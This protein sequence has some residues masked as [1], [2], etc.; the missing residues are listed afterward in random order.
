L[1]SNDIKDYSAI[2]D[3]VNQAARLQAK[4]RATEILVS[5]S[6]YEHVA[7]AYPN[8]Q[9]E[10]LALKGF[11]EPAAA[12]RLNGKPL[13]EFA[14]S[15]WLEGRPA[16]NWCAVTFAIFGSGCLGKDI[17]AAIVLVFGAGSATTLAAL[18]RRLDRS[19]ARLPLLAVTAF[20]ASAVLISLERQRRQRRECL[21][22]SSCL[23]MTPKE[24]RGAYIAAASAAISLG[25]VAFELWQH[26]VLGHPLIKS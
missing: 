12:Y 7:A 16:I 21:S 9:P 5:Q 15:K 19:P 8:L 3:A 4:A 24:K 6:V 11:S 17:A 22:R 26:Y 23:E 18:A 14:G 10:T 20:L 13:T 25:L 1:G 2:G